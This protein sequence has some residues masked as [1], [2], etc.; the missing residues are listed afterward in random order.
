MEQNRSFGQNMCFFVLFTM[1]LAAV[2][3]F[4]FNQKALG[5]SQKMAYEGNLYNSGGEPLTGSYNMRFSIVSV[6][7]GSSSVIWGPETHTGVSVSGGW[8]SVILGENTAISPELFDGSPLYLR[9]EIANP[10]AS[11]NYELMT[12]STAIVSVGTAFRAIEARSAVTVADGSITAAKLAPGSVTKESIATSNVPVNNQYLRW[13]DDSLQWATVS[14][15]TGS[16]EPD[17][18]TITTNIYGSFEVKDL[19]ISNNKL[20]DASV[21]AGKIASRAVTLESIDTGGVPPAS[22]QF[23]KWTGT[24][25]QWASGVQGPT[26]EAGPIGPTGEAG[27]IGPQGIQGPTGEA[28]PVGPQGIQG[29]TGEAGPVGPQGIQGPTGEAGPSGTSSWIDGSGEV[30]TEA[31]VVVGTSGASIES[32][33]G[34]IYGNIFYGDGSGL[35][36][37]M[38]ETVSSDAAVLS[39]A[40]QEA[41][42]LTGAVDIKPGSNIIISQNGQTIEVSSA[43]ITEI[44]DFSVT[45][46]KIA[47]LAVTA[48]KLASGAVTAGAIASENEL[49]PDRYLRWSGTGLDWSAVSG[50]TGSA[51]PDNIT[52]RKNAFGSMEVMP[53]GISSTRI[54]TSAVTAEKL[55]S[56]AA[57]LSI[58]SQEAAR[59]T[60]YVDIKPGSN[61]TII[62]AGQTIEVSSGAISD[63][64]DYSITASKLGT[65]AVTAEKISS[66]SVT[67][68]S[69]A[70][71]TFSNITGLG[72]LESL[73][74]SGEVVY[75]PSVAHDVS[76]GSGITGS[77]LANKII[78][79]QGSGGPVTIT[80]DPPIAS[81]TNG[82]II[83][84]RGMDET[85]TVTFDPGAKLK[86]SGGYSFTLGDHDSLMLSYD[87][88]DELWFELARSDN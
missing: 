16:V 82:Q 76:A 78:R 29:P 10:P 66:G 53:L 39:I 45:S 80:S 83:I 37:V 62:Q 52:I 9:I 72:T 67:N 20:S 50:G 60:G 41:A 79:V 58:A 46:T 22:D 6:S 88:A 28:G 55:A 24:S 70:T 32:A 31:N 71:G 40:S 17:E 3:S 11:S 57:V 36:N 77:M 18:I 84:L 81:G 56:D 23:L 34:N 44:P 7:E 25:M 13:R 15:G 33:T 87:G 43:A 27:P 74:V 73:A 54:A 5:I 75:T 35:N 21:T 61:I 63:I 65:S 48:E 2:F 12:P 51:E 38:A 26:G 85:N 68:E 64:P 30:T 14:G 69:L 59:L 42:R 4:A 47:T 1:S 86:L 19:G 8:F 49:S